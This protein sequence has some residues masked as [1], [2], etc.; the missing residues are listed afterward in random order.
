MR[1]NVL[2]TEQS[3]NPYESPLAI[4]EEQGH[5][6]PTTGCWKR[7]AARWFVLLIGC[8]V[9]AF[10]LYLAEFRPGF[11]LLVLPVLYSTLA[12]WKIVSEP[13]WSDKSRP[14]RM[15]FELILGIGLFFYGVFVCLFALISA[16]WFVQQ[17]FGVDRQSFT[18]EHQL[19]CALLD[20]ALMT[21]CSILVLWLP[22]TKRL[23]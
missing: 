2:V 22:W 21:L 4:T 9:V 3:E 13:T 17:F 10:G 16:V 7:R 15:A 18:P 6:C 11:L 20:F 8:L 14:K 5:S 19:Y 12:I 1:G 23:E